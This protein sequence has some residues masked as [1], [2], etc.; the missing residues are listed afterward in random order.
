MPSVSFVER[1]GEMRGEVHGAVRLLR[2][3]LKTRFGPLPPETDTRV[4]AAPIDRLWT[5]G[6]R[7]I[8]TKRLEAVFAETAPYVTDQGGPTAGLSTPN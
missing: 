1:R 8:A 3:L 2:D 4:D 7:V 5:W 6:G